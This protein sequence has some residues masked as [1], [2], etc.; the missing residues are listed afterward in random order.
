MQTDARTKHDNRPIGLFDSG[1]G[2]L[3]VV[4]AVRRM[5][6]GEDVIYLGD[7]ARVP[8]G[9]R[10]AETVKQFARQDLAFLE[11]FGIKAAIAACNTV[12]A[13][14]LPELQQEPRPFPLGG[15]IVAGVEAI[16]AT[17][18]R[19]V[20]VL[21]TRGT[22]ASGAYEKAL[23]AADP[24]LIVRS[25]SC[26]LF[27]PVIE[28][29]VTGGEIVRSVFDLYLSQL[30]RD[31][32]EVVLL[33]CTHYPLF[34]PALKRYL[35]ADTLILDSADAA[36]DYL[37]RM[38]ERNGLSAEPGRTGTAQYYVTDRTP[39]FERLARRFLDAGDGET[40]DIRMADVVGHD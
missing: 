35:P 38:L 40:I 33:G 22:I 10:S 30:L 21:G 3:T 12:S 1:L 7:T 9:N 36:A 39:G 18:L 15:V 27:V 31:P 6:P 37:R 14:A 24:R 25:I 2:G 11:R 34:R 26:P 17:G 19:K 23:L 8:Y 16:L 32:P 5:L 29:G 28:E 13:L 4:R 20:A